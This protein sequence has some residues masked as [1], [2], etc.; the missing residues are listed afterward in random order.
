MTAAEP[1][2]YQ[3][4]GMDCADCAVEIEHAVRSLPGVAEARV[5]L[6]SGL[7]TVHLRDQA[8]IPPIEQTVSAL[9]YGATPVG[10]GAARLAPGYRRALAI[11]VALNLGYGVVETIG[12]F[13]S[14]SQAVKA[15]ALDFLG[16]GLISLLGL[17]AIGWS[18]VWR[19]RA[20]FLQGLF[21][22]PLGLGVLG[23][24][25]LP[26]DRAGDPGGR[27]DG[28][29]GAGRPGGQRRRGAGR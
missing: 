2:R 11:V 16:D 29:A 15:D 23:Y 22:G 26:R 5:S 27:A 18:L 9:G 21:L 8:A 12:G 1:V 10:A 28:R 6:A 3:V 25:A 19:A 14:G 20:A 4:T 17:L 24:D 13:L 7:M